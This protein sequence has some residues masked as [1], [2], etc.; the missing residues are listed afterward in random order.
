VQPAS[1]SLFGDRDLKGLSVYSG[2]DKIGSVD[3]V[4]VDDEG[5]L[6]YLVIDTGGWI[7]WKKVLLPIGYA[8]IDDAGR[9]VYANNLT[10]A[11]IEALPKFTD[12]MMLDYNREEQVR[13]V[14][15]SSMPKMQQDIAAG[16][17]GDYT[18]YDRDTYTY[19]REP[20]L[21]SLNDQNHPSLKLYEE[22]LVASKTRQKT[23]ETVISKRVETETA[24]AA[25]AIEQER[26][27][28]ERI[29]AN[30]TTNV[31]VEIVFNDKSST[32]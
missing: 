28:V 9:H 17:G 6:R 13:D 4:L 5:Q 16:S 15:R 32:D 7:L 19:D 30:S 14:Y 11:Q 31:R 1:R 8:T 12:E 24:Q 25:V 26:V 3:D 27:V 18:G 2:D 29:P 21:Y 22:R 10:K 20:E 23:G